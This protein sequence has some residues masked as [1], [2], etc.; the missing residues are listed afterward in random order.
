LP[1]EGH[2]G[3]AAGIVENRLQDRKILDAVSQDPL[4][5]EERFAFPEQAAQVLGVQRADVR[6]ERKGRG[7]LGEVSDAR[8]AVTIPRKEE[9]RKGPSGTA[10]DDSRR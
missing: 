3:N 4:R 5:A 9:P 8:V 7:R 10:P 6:K 2:L 1:I